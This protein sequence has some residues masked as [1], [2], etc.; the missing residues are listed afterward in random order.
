MFDRHLA[1]ARSLITHNTYL[2]AERER[3]RERERDVASSSFSSP[4]LQSKALLYHLI[5]EEPYL[6][7]LH[8]TKMA[9]WLGTSQDMAL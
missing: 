2:H 3:E 5:Q 9:C 8:R 1:D 6:I 4:N 7:F